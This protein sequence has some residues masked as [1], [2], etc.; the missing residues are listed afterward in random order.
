VLRQQQRQTDGQLEVIKES[1]MRLA[2]MMSD[3]LSSVRQELQ[4]E[5]SKQVHALMSRWN[6]VET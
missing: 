6:Q 3:E 1:V 4:G 2:E 5:V